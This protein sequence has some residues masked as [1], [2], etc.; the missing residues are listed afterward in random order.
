M[1]P[2]A[3]DGGSFAS[4]KSSAEDL[5]TYSGGVWLGGYTLVSDKTIFG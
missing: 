1:G 4:E 5:V 3:S 2:Q